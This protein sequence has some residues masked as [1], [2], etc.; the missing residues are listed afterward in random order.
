MKV[1]EEQMKKM[2]KSIMGLAARRGWDYDQ[3]HDL[4]EDWGYGRSLRKLDFSELNNI[5]RHLS[6][7]TKEVNEINQLDDQ[8]R[9]MWAMMKKAGWNWKRVRLLMIKKYNTTHWNALT[10]PEKKAIIGILRKYA[11]GRNNG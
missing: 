2:R 10:E 8:G 11:E 5:L 4:M 3:F 1:R 9:Y 6:G 7:G